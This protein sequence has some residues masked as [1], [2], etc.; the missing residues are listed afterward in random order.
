[1]YRNDEGDRFQRAMGLMIQS[2]RSGGI[3]STSLL[4]AFASIPRHLFVSEALRYRAYE[5][6]SLPIGFGQTI[7]RPSTIARMLQVCDI[8][9]SSRVLEVGTGSGYQAALLSVLCGKVVTCER[10]HDLHT[11]ARQVLFQLGLNNVHCVYNDNGGF[12]GVR[13][14]YDVIIVAAVADATPPGLIEFMAPGG[15]MVVPVHS[16]SGQV[17]RR[18]SREESGSVIEEDIGDANFVPLVV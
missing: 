4:Q 15:V 13:G 14:E 12:D 6:T 3:Y 8:R 9:S 16:N 5:D 18:Y 1:M 11:R 10:I 7:S 17:L 2:L